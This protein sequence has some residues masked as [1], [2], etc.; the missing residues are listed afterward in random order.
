MVA[1]FFSDYNSVIFIL[2]AAGSV[3]SETSCK[4]ENKLKVKVF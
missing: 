1:L 4:G 2:S 3:L